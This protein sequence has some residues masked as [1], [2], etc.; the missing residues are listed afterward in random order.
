VRP[1]LVSRAP[2]METLLLSVE[3]SEDEEASVAAL[4]NRRLAVRSTRWPESCG[5]SFSS[6]CKERRGYG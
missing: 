3:T 4:T 1:Y 6:C 2:E 5:A